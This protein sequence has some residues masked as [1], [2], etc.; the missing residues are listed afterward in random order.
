MQTKEATNQTHETSRTS[1]PKTAHTNDQCRGWVIHVRLIR[2]PSKH[3]PKYLL[4]FFRFFF[5]LFFLS[6]HQIVP[7]K[8]PE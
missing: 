4:H 1:K 7:V 5:Q 2:S 6:F 8:S 3:A